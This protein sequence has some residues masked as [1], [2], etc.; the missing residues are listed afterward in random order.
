MLF[1]AE[2]KSST[3]TTREHILHVAQELF[4]EFGYEGTSTRLIA[5]ESGSNIGMISYYFGSKEQLF[6]TII[7][8]RTKYIR[9][10]LKNLNEQSIPSWDK[11]IYMLDA[12]VDRMLSAPKFTQMIF[13]ELTLS[14]RPHITD[15]V[16]EILDRNR[17]E[18]CK[19][20]HDGQKTGEFRTD[21]DVEMCVG[22]FYGTMFQIINASRVASAFLGYDADYDVTSPELRIRVKNHLLTLFRSL[23]LKQG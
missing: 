3:N 15:K 21:I 23:L 7:D 5:K 12:Y 17:I 2:E 9:I 19:L 11:F 10:S 20:L 8:E 13:R 22:T 18:M 1:S 14:Q 6:L 16:I 4:A